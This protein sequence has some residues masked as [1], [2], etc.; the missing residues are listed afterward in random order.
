MVVN[1]PFHHFLVIFVEYLHG[2]L[3]IAIMVNLV[4]YILLK[5]SYFVSFETINTLLDEK[6][7]LMMK[8]VTCGT[9]AIAI[10]AQLTWKV[11]HVIMHTLHESLNGMFSSQVHK[12]QYLLSMIPFYI[13]LGGPE[14]TNKR[15][16]GVLG[17]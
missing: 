11:R 2:F 10:L 14:V 7:I 4:C 1:C 5:F 6:I 12:K 13:F 17:G 16:S 15:N 8:I 9:A 3:Y